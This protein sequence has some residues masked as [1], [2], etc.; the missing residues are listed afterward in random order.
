MSPDPHNFAKTRILIQIKYTTLVLL[1]VVSKS[2]VVQL[3]QVVSPIFRI[4]S[5]FQAVEL[6][7]E[8]LPELRYDEELND[9]R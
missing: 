2:S 7:K 5:K 9:Y 6:Q 4:K 8:E 3:L 1:P